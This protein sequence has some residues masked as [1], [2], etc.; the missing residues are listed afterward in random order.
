MT[1]RKNKPTNDQ[2][3]RYVSRRLEGESHVKAAEAEKIHEIWHQKADQEFQAIVAR[4]AHDD[5]LPGGGP[6][7]L[8]GAIMAQG[9]RK[10]AYHQ[11]IN[12]STLL[13][14]WVDLATASFVMVPTVD[15][16]G[17]MTYQ[18]VSVPPENIN[19]D[20]SVVL[21]GEVYPKDA[22]VP[23]MATRVAALRELTK[24]T[25]FTV[26][27]LAKE[28]ALKVRMF[29]ELRKAQAEGSKTG[30]AE[31]R[32]IRPEQKPLVVKAVEVKRERKK[33]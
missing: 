12:P 13:K 26:R 7:S 20:G 4:S 6:L 27:D 29:S 24:M 19:P 17:K 21:L 9:I 14:K 16:K 2:M 25:G 11:N 22:V 10:E 1:V 33:D 8:T 15:D 23:D 18:K 5:V 28:D 3:R 32:I 31:V 30:G